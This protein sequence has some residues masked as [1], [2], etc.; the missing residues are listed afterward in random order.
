M[1]SVDDDPV[2]NMLSKIEGVSTN[3]QKSDKLLIEALNRFDLSLFKYSLKLTEEDE[4]PKV[5][6]RKDSSEQKKTNDEKLETKQDISN[7]TK[8]ELVEQDQ[9]NEQK[10]PNEPNTS[11]QQNEE[12]VLT[13]PQLQQNKQVMEQ[14]QNSNIW[15]MLFLIREILLRPN[16]CIELRLRIIHTSIL[17]TCVCTEKQHEY[18][19]DQK[20]LD[21]FK[22]ILQC[23]HV[24]TLE[25]LIE[26]LGNISAETQE[27]NTLLMK[28]GLVQQVLQLEETHVNLLNLFKN[29]Q[30]SLVL[31]WAAVQFAIYATNEDV[32]RVFIPRIVKHLSYFESNFFEIQLNWFQCLRFCIVDR[33]DV[34]IHEF[35]V[36]Y[37]PELI[38]QLVQWLK[39]IRSMDDEP[40]ETKDDELDKENKVD[41]ETQTALNDSKTEKE[42]K[43]CI[44]ILVIDHKTGAVSKT[45]NEEENIVT[46]LN[47]SKE[48]KS[49]LLYVRIVILRILGNMI[50]YNKQI[51]KLLVK[52]DAVA[53]FNTLVHSKCALTRQITCWVLS[54][55]IVDEC[56]ENL[57]IRKTNIIPNIMQSF[58]KE[59]DVAVIIEICW[60]MSSLLNSPENYLPILLDLGIVETFTVLCKS[61]DGDD[62]SIEVLGTIL[63]TFHNVLKRVQCSPT[64][65]YFHNFDETIGALDNLVFKSHSFHLAYYVN[66]MSL[67]YLDDNCPLSP[68]QEIP[69]DL[70]LDLPYV[71]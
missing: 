69:V 66:E 15:F 4:A 3:L 9:S 65:C 56:A 14:S 16:L 71:L 37:H 53:E 68:Q 46:E 44:E 13:L 59:N 5:K 17:I 54:N 60:M 58:A 63:E 27:I 47:V 7:E 21:K 51:S 48:T 33:P 40:I 30:L 34:E 25:Y 23:N 6:T 38:Q 57:F 1:N 11:N 29:P 64:H 67:L 61:L 42:G 35:I 20:T 18:F 52:C 12:K 22:E 43:R 26:L 31:S 24:M 39:T 28:S 32:C 8:Q 41:K 55:L 19:L 62:L 36:A 70:S 45:V 49:D 10:Q 50:L 2:L